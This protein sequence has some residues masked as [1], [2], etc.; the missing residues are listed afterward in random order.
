MARKE[1]AMIELT[2]EQLQALGAAS[3][4]PPRARNP[5]TQ[6]TFA[7]IRQDVYELVRQIIDGPNRRGWDDPELDV[8][9]EGPIQS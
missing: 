2:E 5:L 4:S 6:E 7:L 8:Y 3:E 9:G 1:A